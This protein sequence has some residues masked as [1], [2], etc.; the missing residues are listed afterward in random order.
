MRFF[1]EDAYGLEE[2]AMGGR[3]V[4]FALND[5][6]IIRITRILSDD[7]AQGALAF[8]GDYI[9][10]RDHASLDSRSGGKKVLKK[11]DIIIRDELV[12]DLLSMIESRDAS[13][14]LSFLREHFEREIKAALIP[15]CVPVFESS[16]KPNQADEYATQSEVNDSATHDMPTPG[17]DRGQKEPELR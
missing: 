4:D 13:G 15:H 16:Y 8:F 3:R 11:C 1:L 5:E 6:G 12:F 2:V 9:A 17:A 7:D 14:C 10:G